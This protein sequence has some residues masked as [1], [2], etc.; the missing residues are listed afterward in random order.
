MPTG[1]SHGVFVRRL[2]SPPLGRGWG[3]AVYTNENEL[4]GAKLQANAVPSPNPSPREG[5]R[6]GPYAIVL[7]MQSIGVSYFTRGDLCSNPPL[8]CQ[9]VFQGVHL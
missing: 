3:R 7:P 6:S 2:N 4:C 5:D 9:K 1:Q 8:T